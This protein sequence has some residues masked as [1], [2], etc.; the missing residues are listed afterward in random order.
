[1]VL[2]VGRSE[3]V[4]Q[5]LEKAFLTDSLQRPMIS[6]AIMNPHN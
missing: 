1:M 4:G 2:E 6:H 5:H 3:V